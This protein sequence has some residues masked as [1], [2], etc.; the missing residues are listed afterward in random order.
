VQNMQ[1]QYYRADLLPA[2]RRAGLSFVA[3]AVSLA[4]TGCSST[5]NATSQNGTN[6]SIG[7]NTLNVADAA[8][9][10]GDAQM[11]LSV[12]QSILEQDPNNVDALVHEGD[13]YYAL[14]RC[15]ASVSS[16]KQAL[17]Y[18]PK[19]SAA[20]IGLGRCLLK[21]DPVQAAAAFTAATQDDP[22]NAAA[23]ANLGIA[24][25]LQGNFAGAASAYQQSLT[26]DAGST[27]T[28]VNY[29]LSLALS[30]QGEQALQYLGPIATGPGAT[31]KIR[32]D[33]AVA[34]IA[35]GRNDDARQ[36][37]SIDLTPDKVNQTMAAF[38][39]LISQNVANPAPPPPP[40]P[41]D[42]AVPT[43]PVAAA[44]IPQASAAPMPLAPVASAVPVA[45]PVAAPVAMETAPPPPAPPPVAVAQPAAPAPEMAQAAMPAP[46]KPIVQPKPVVAAPM[47]K[48]APTVATA[49]PE[50]AP[51]A[52]A[53]TTGA[54]AKLD[55]AA[56][57]QPAPMP[58][59][60]PAVTAQPEIKPA[61][62]AAAPAKPAATVPSPAEVAAITPVPVASPASPQPV[63]DE[64][65]PPPA[66]SETAT[67]SATSSANGAAVQIAALNTSAAAQTEWQ[68]V[69]ALAPALFA[70]KEPQISKVEVGGA[71]YYRLRVG[72][73]ASQ[74]EAAQFCSHL[75]A[76]GSPCMPANF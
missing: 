57:T 31:P 27:P 16:Y 51:A 43:A 56:A 37:L 59:P 17:K 64:A 4:M 61:A 52:S 20:Q 49:Q 71:T 26:I 54:P 30:G 67:S 42:M 18:D 7:P 46:A 53:A 3:L 63:S 13:A 22:G 50:V 9:A 29:G 10:G 33:Y 76:A 35:V 12:S 60:A 24:L 11:A 15:P 21:Y 36:V 5:T 23:F 68:K 70:G 19:S 41:T 14:G 55:V 45:A 65:P 74:D 66:A 40:A 6:G 28:T 34:L 25:D 69:S 2:R 39:S 8:L 47:P 44:P 72:G 75:T 62:M 32:Q 58:K 48:P 73:F 1:R 38:Q